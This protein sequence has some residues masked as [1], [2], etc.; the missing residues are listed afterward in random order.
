MKPR[1]V[2][3]TIALGSNLGDRAGQLDRALERLG[4][5][6]GTRLVARSR[7]HETEPMGGPAGQPRFLN[8][9]V[10]LETD[11]GP[12]ELLAALQRIELEAGRRRELEPR[13]GPRPLDL[14]LL[15]YADLRLDEPALQLPHPRMEERLFVLEPLAEIAP[16]ERLPGCGKSVRERVRE[17]RSTGAGA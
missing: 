1:A 5:L 10:R 6:P 7:W 2:L 3:A 12:R 8:G 16:D 9:V 13:H 17:L 15:G 14:D 4:A 11:L